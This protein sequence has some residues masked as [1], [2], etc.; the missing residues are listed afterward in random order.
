MEILLKKFSFTIKPLNI[1]KFRDS[2][3]NYLGYKKIIYNSN[4]FEFSLLP[5][6]YFI[7]LNSNYPYNRNNGS[8]IPNRGYQHILSAGFFFKL[9][10][11]S[12]KFNPEHQFSQNKKFEGFW[13]GHY[14]IIWQ[15]RYRL[16]NHIDSP[17]RFGEKRHNQRLLG[18]SNVKLNWK[19]ISL[20]F[21]N[22][23]IWWGP[24]IRNSIM[25]S[26]HATGFKHLTFNTSSPIDT[27]IGS[28]EW[29]VISGRL[30]SSTYTP[31]G[32]DKF[33]AGQRLYFEKINQ[34]GQMNDWRY[35]QGYIFTYSP[36]FIDGLSLGFIRWVQMYRS[37][38]EGQYTWFKGKPDYFP[39][40]KNLFR[41]NDLYADYE[42]HTDQAAGIFFR[43]LWADAKAEIYGEFNLNDAKLNFRDFLQDTDHSRAVTF[44]L[45]KIFKFNSGGDYLFQWEWTQME[46]SASRLV[47]NAN[48]WY[49][50][51][52]IYHG[53][54]NF[55]EVLGSG[56]GPGSNSHYLSLSRVNGL[57]NYGISIE[58]V[59]NDNDF[60]YEAFT[61]SKDFRRYWKD[62]NLHLN[63]QKKF[64]NLLLSSKLI[65]IKSLNYQWALDESVSSE[66]FKPGIDKN[67]FHMSL[68]LSYLFK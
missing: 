30:E 1:S 52:W 19:K 5:I 36:S 7:E 46:Q 23:N 14:P 66:Y 65:F 58:I 56:I 63:F 42:S 33:Y 16:W 35:F 61:D 29:Q 53:Y 32:T 57:D 18:Q 25:M 39:I 31:P 38:L 62:L 41:N 9:G 27:K 3:N 22:E 4:K 45:Q 15:R 6:D 11:L 67:N 10:P 50:H 47:R 51:H 37:M 17:E 8:M 20:G 49:E 12:I 44:G 13:E 55:G 40:F 48:S 43:W 34:M 54:T 68:K 24:S 2:V 28:F 60:Y 21:S 26:N 59:D 64:K